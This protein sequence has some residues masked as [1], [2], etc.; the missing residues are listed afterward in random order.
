[1]QHNFDR[2]DAPAVSAVRALGRMNSGSEM[3]AQHMNTESPPGRIMIGTM[4]L[5]RT[6]QG[7]RGRTHSEWQQRPAP[8]R[9]GADDESPLH[10]QLRQPGRHRGGRPGSKRQCRR[11]TP[12][13][14]ERR[15]KRRQFPQPPFQPR[16]KERRGRYGQ[17]RRRFINIILRGRQTQVGLVPVIGRRRYGTAIR[18]LP[19]TAAGS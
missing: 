16:R 12:R 10:P 7:G 19:S 13:V 3:Q 18:Q 9:W 1:M 11:K 14:P 17:R 6:S 2:Q 5:H 15:P 4:H 8:I